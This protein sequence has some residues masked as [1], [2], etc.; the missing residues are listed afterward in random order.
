MKE[1]TYLTNGA[2]V[3]RVNT[4]AFKKRPELFRGWRVAKPDEVIAAGLEA[5]V[6][7]SEPKA[8]K[9][10][11]KASKEEISDTKEAL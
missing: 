7:K 8:P 10:N 9:K 6:V 3:Q 5:N 11:D 4:D 2:K 1:I